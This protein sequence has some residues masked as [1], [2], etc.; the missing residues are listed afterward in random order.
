MGLKE[1]LRTVFSVIM[2][3][4]VLSLYRAPLWVIVYISTP[5]MII[6]FISIFAHGEIVRSAYVG[7]LISIIVSNGL[8]IHGDA[9]IY[10]VEVKL[11][12]MLVASPCKPV[13][14]MFGLA[15]S[16]LVYSTPGIIIFTAI[17]AHQGILTVN[18]ATPLVAIVIMSW[19]VGV[20]IGFYL[21][22][23]I[24]DFRHVWALGTILSTTLTILPPV[25]YPIT[26]LPKWLRAIAYI[27]PTTHAAQLAKKATGIISM[28]MVE[29]MLSWIALITYTALFILLASRKSRWREK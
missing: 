11:Q 28:D 8:Y 13:A 18:N 4:G 24:T 25:Y 19:C 17:L 2:V 20:G 21:S 22:T 10:R 5:L 29:E 14:Y 27:A 3:N 9:L 26:L 6:L 16:E 1:S 7:G 23:L 12:D 15:L